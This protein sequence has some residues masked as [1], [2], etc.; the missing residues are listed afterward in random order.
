MTRLPILKVSHEPSAEDLV[1]LYHRAILHLTRHLGEEAALDAGT[2]FTNPEMDRVDDANVLLDAAV[3]EG[4]GPGAVMREVEEH[5]RA[6]GTRCRSVVPNPAAP[7]SMTEPLVAHLRSSGWRRHAADILHLSGAPRSPIREIA[8][9]TIVPAR[10]SFRHTRALA[11]ECAAEAGEPQLADAIMAHLDDPHWDALLAL[12]DGA[13]VATIGV[14][15]VGDVGTIDEVYVA[16]DHRR[17]GIGRTMMG[18][19]L[20]ICARSLFKHVML[21]VPPQNE[22]AQALYGAL[23]F[24]KIGE[25][26][27]YRAAEV[28]A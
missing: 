18:R 6:A 24:R 28:T 5:F 12:K 26:V 2:A 3:P 23:G 13:A 1:R 8:G 17:Q 19:A 16:K 7:A 15:A 20:E 21:G 4:E 11:E 9:L 27:S 25:I 22:P 10:A 14:L